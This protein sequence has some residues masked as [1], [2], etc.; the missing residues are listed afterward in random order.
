MIELVVKTAITKW[1]FL[2]HK[3]KE[4]KSAFYREP[5]NFNVKRERLPGME[6]SEKSLAKL[7]KP[8]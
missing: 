5:D 6:I 1:I 3:K 2:L 7:L 8:F 4:K